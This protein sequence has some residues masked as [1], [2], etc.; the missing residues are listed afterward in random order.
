MVRACIRGIRDG[1]DATKLRTGLA[2]VD[3]GR[4]NNVLQRQEYGLTAKICLLATLL[5]LES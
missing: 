4:G 1:L 3:H 2:V 5:S